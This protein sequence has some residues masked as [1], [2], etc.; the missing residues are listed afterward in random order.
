MGLW[1]EDMM[2]QL[3]YPTDIPNIEIL[4]SIYEPLI[5]TKV[6]HYD[7]CNSRYV[8]DCSV[9]H[10]AIDILTQLGHYL[11]ENGEIY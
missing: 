11:K 4:E 2:C 8:R 6:Y 1:F 10:S 3:L 7:D 9:I 5:Y